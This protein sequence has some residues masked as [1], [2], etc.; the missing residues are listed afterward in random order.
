[1]KD[2][3]DREGC[4]ECKRQSDKWLCFSII[5]AILLAFTLPIVIACVINSILDYKIQMFLIENA[6]DVCNGVIDL[7]KDKGKP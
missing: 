6:T 2:E 5:G 1:M 3:E 4:E 7:F